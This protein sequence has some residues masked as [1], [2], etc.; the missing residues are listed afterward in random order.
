MTDGGSLL[1]RFIRELTR[2]R[3]FRV[4]AV[5]AA[6]AWVVV[7]VSDTVAPLL[8]LPD[9]TSTLVLVLVL[10]GFPVVIALAWTFD[11][12]S[13]GIERTAPPASGPAGGS[14]EGAERT[15]GPATAAA[16][17]RWTAGR[18]AVVGA[19][20]VLALAGAAMVFIRPTSGP[21]PS[22]SAE[23]ASNTDPPR[24]SLA[25]ALYN[26]PAVAML[27][28]ENLGSED[29]RLFV[30][31]LHDDILTALQKIGGLTV[32][33]RTSVLQY[34]DAP[35]P[36]PEVAKELRVDAVGEGSVSRAGDRIRVNVQ[37]IHG[38]T[39]AHLWSEQYDRELTTENVFEIR[40]E[41]ARSVARSLKVTLTPEEERR[42][43]RQPTSSLNAKEW[44]EI[45]AARPDWDER[46]EAYRRALELDST[47]APAWALLANAY[48]IGWAADPAYQDS[49]LALA[50]RALQLDPETARAYSAKGIVHT[51]AG[52]L[53][54]ALELFRTAAALDPGASYAWNNMGVVADASG[55]YLEALDAYRRAVRLNPVSRQSSANIV[56]IYLQLGLHDRARQE[57][58]QHLKIHPYDL[59][60]LSILHLREGRI[61][62]ARAVADRH[63]ELNP[64]I[65]SP[66]LIAAWFASIAGDW[67]AA[68]EYAEAAYEGDPRQ[69]FLWRPFTAQTLLA[70]LLQQTADHGEA[71]RLFGSRLDELR[72]DRTSSGL[73]FMERGTI[74]AARN[75]VEEAI[76]LLEQGYELDKDVPSFFFELTP[77]Y[78]P[79][80][81]HP[82]FQ[83]FLTRARENEA[84]EREKVLRLEAELQAAR[85]AARRES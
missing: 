79:L 45:G 26:N 36:V 27:P 19:M 29:D 46:A 34:R 69:R 63:I 18:I 35:K 51:N 41:I 14:V 44:V 15:A 22:G 37:L 4:A 74:L 80:R 11:L 68:L 39:D 6:A 70:L 73:A 7:E 72:S 24:V 28:L 31:G 17:G 40:T 84:R 32:I 48:A 59:L 25:D 21:S 76:E 61:D 12:T 3:V 56:E 60:Y 42:V 62:S 8:L 30:A 82:A 23:L 38:E 55:H 75:Q 77:F 83:R 52:Q 49:A 5:Y 65:E 13:G 64:S 20:A 71:E 1:Q 43:A 81:D 50:D 10:L 66:L 54:R 2:R 67:P 58:D 85:L 57:L 53:D 33:S 78:D 16:R 9:W 47:Y